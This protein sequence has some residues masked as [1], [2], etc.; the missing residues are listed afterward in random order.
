M[1]RRRLYTRK[2]G[3]DGEGVEIGRWILPEDVR[4]G[5]WSPM[6]PRDTREA[7]QAPAAAPAQPAADPSPQGGVADVYDEDIPF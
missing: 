6:A 2:D 1:L 7:A 3:T 4:S 5:N